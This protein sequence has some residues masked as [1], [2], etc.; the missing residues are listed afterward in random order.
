MRNSRRGRPPSVRLLWKPWRPFGHANSILFRDTARRVRRSA[1]GRVCGGTTSKTL[2]AMTR[3]KETGRIDILPMLPNDGAVSF[4][5]TN[6]IVV[7]IG[8]LWSAKY[9]LTMPVDSGYA[10][11]NCFHSLN[12]RPKCSSFSFLETPSKVPP[13]SAVPSP[14]STRGTIDGRPWAHWKGNAH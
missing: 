3:L 5:T 8:Y 11:L 9:A 2:W 13:I 10:R 1:T 14:R 6:S 4:W 12:L 7:G